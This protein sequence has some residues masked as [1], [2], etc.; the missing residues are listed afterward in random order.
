MSFQHTV[1]NHTL[2]TVL[3]VQPHASWVAGIKAAIQLQEPVTEAATNSNGVSNVQSPA[4]HSAR[5][6]PVTKPQACVIMAA[7][8]GTMVPVLKVRNV[9]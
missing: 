7:W 8:M 1:L 5:T 4:R 6:T 2:T 9:H 3:T